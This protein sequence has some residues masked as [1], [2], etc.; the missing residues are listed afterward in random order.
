MIYF[1][2]FGMVGVEVGAYFRINARRS[3]AFLAYSLVTSRHTIHIGR[4]ASEVGKIAFEV[5]HIYHLARFF[6]NTFL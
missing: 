5:G 1:E 3:F 2:K 6:Q 4:R